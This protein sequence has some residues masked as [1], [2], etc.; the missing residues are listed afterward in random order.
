[1]HAQLPRLLQSTKSIA[2]TSLSASKAG[3]I[4]H[5][6]LLP[7]PFHQSRASATLSR[8]GDDGV[9]TGEAACGDANG[10]AT[11]VSLCRRRVI[12]THI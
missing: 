4:S 5:A 9:A 10:L 8:L 3:R 11:G 7:S 1:M 6:T 12:F 2:I